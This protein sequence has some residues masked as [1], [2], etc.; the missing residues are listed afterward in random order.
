MTLFLSLVVIIIT[1]KQ[2]KI[3]A[4]KD[5]QFIFNDVEDDT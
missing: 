5:T 3:T 4:Q 1:M 2:Q